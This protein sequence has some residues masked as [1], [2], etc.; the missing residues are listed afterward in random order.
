MEEAE[1][2]EKSK[3]V[4]YKRPPS[5][6]RFKPG[7]SGNPGG[8]PK[9]GLKDYDRK[10]FILMSD[11]EKDAFLRRIAPELRYRMAE[12]NPAQQLEGSPDNPL[13]QII[14]DSSFKQDATPRTTEGNNKEQ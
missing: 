1:N 12:G 3:E 6:Y 8:R 4:G 2:R 10:K 11:E 14:F 7:V 13:V 5:E 9:G